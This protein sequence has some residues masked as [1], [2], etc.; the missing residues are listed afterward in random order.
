MIKEAGITVIHDAERSMTT[1]TD[2]A[3]DQVFELDHDDSIDAAQIE[4]RMW[5]A[6]ALGGTAGLLGCFGAEHI[7]LLPA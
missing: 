3:H 2:W 5:R 4:R 1:L 7:R 6:Y